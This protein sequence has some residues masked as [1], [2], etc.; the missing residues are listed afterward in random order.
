MK[1]ELHIIDTLWLGG[2]Q[3]LLKLYFEYLKKNR[4]IYLFV[5]RQTDGA[6]IIK[7]KNVTICNTSKKI[8]AGRIR[9]ICDLITENRIEIVHCHLQNSLYHGIQLKKK[10][11]DSI[12]LFFHDHAVILDSKKAV[13]FLVKRNASLIDG[14]FVCSHH[15]G[16][17]YKNIG[18]G[19]EH[20]VFYLP[21][22]AEKY[23]IE[24][25][26]NDVFTIGFAGRLVE[27]K[28]WRDL[29]GAMEVLVKEMQ[30]RLHIAGDGPDREK[31]L[32]YIENKGLSTRVVY[33]GVQRNI[34]EFFRGIDLLIIPSHWEGMPLVALEAMH[35]GI[36]VV[37]ADAPGLNEFLKDGR[38][39][40]LA[41]LSDPAGLASKIMTLA[42][43][44]GL[45]GGLAAQAREDAADYTI[46]RYVEHLG[47][48]TGE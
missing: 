32:K 34:S 3:A 20:K 43:N 44:P 2:A 25:V 12:R 7:H 24:K 23:E 38:N 19:L 15:T 35:I 37:A 39:C 13:S 16:S 18:S 46:E 5:L 33:E 22:A 29:L 8:S 26:P 40:Q 27:R 30:V 6:V 4:N 14:I 10:L 28:G 48:Y 47:Q 36:P 31:L 11:N 9:Q 41:K 42:E 45:R 1:R 21:N 17:I